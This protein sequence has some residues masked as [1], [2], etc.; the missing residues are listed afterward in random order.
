MVEVEKKDKE[1]SESLIRR[2]SRRMQQSRVLMKA[3]K[4]R[5]LTKKK[6]KRVLRDDALYRQNMKKEVDKLKKM[7]KFD[8]DNFKDIKKKILNKNK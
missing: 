8:E 1:T 5:F 6:T 4:G 3:R 7:G 2:F